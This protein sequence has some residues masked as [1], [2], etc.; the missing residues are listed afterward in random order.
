MLWGAGATP[1]IPMG[2]LTG[3]RINVVLLDSHKWRSAPL[4][5]AVVKQHIL[6][7]AIVVAAVHLPQ[8]VRRRARLKTSDTIC[9]PISICPKRKVGRQ[10]DR[11]VIVLR[12]HIVFAVHCEWIS[13]AVAVI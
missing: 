8:Q 6:P 4:D 3:L 9:T 7:T 5:T 1:H 11:I 12:M 2:C 13:E 10:L